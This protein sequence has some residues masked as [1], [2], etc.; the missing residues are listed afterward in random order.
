MDESTQEYKYLVF[1]GASTKIYAYLG[2]IQVLEEKG[3]IGKINTFLGTSSGSIISLLLILGYT[4]E[5]IKKIIFD[6]DTDKYGGDICKVLGIY[7]MYSTYGY[8]NP[9]KYI[10]WIKDVIANKTGNGNITFQELYN[11]TKK[12]LIATGTCLNKRESHYYHRFSNGNM[13]VFKAIQISTA[14]PFLFPPINWKGDILVDGG[15]LENY[16]IYYIKPD[17]SFPN[18]RKEIV[19]YNHKKHKKINEF[20]L[21]VKVTS[22]QEKNNEFNDQINGLIDFGTSIFNT[23]LTQIER[24]SIKKGYYLNTIEIVIPNTIN[25]FQLKLSTESK[26]QLFTFG[27]NFTINFFDKKEIIDD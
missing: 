18:T 25:N 26:E 15:I 23:L 5:E 8:V 12:D 10:Q 24:N 9:E 6:V 16:P 3:I 22:T 14:L 21:G 19:K 2:A 4:S 7:N 13:P 1:E 17:G 20:T 27:K 11:L